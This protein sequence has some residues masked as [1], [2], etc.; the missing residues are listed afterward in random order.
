MAGG[1]RVKGKANV[2]RNLRKLAKKYPNAAVAGLFKEEMNMIGEAK[3]RTPVD[4]GR[5]RSSG[6]AVKPEIKG[7]EISGQIGFDTN[8]AAAVHERTELHHTVGEA[9][10]LENAM[11]EEQGGMADRIARYIE[12]AVGL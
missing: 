10:F 6:H 12:G 5:L 11:N 3:V 1:L 2:Q 9:K 8:Y 7:N 4:T